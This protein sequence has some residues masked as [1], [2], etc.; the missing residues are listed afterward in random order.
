M[1][2]FDD[3]LSSIGGKKAPS[4]PPRPQR[5]P[6]TSASQQLERPGS[7]WKPSPA[8]GNGVKRK[9]EDEI[10]RGKDR[11]FKSDSSDQS[12]DATQPNGDK[13]MNA[14]ENKSSYTSVAAAK[15]PSKG[16]FA[17]MMARAKVA[18]QQR[19]GN[20][21]GMI[22]HQAGTKEK[23]L[24]MAERQKG[25]NGKSGDSESKSTS[26]VLSN[27]KMNQ[28]GNADSQLPQ[29][30]HKNSEGASKSPL[31]LKA[32]SAYKG[33]MGRSARK[34]KDGSTVG[35]SNHTQNRHPRSSNYNEYL[36]T[37]E[38][39][40]SDIIDDDDEDGDGNDSGS[41]GSSDMEAGVSDLEAEEARALRAAKQDD[42]KELEHELQHKREKEER[43]RRLQAMAKKNR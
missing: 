31:P 25:S 34:L 8:T 37:D 3:I 22:K 41:E 27:G 20:Q 13:A 12:R 42:A 32:K 23:I 19:G 29:Q 24:K 6:A 1:S 40:G 39:D 30:R 17:D 7:S 5:P 14:L 35:R 15:A 38:E 11:I 16:S 2:S 4:P 9:A 21:V 43:K 10:P 36:D 18:Q 26:K 28:R 33:T